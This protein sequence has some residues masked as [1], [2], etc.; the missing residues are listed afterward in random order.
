MLAEFKG[1]AQLRKAAVRRG[2]KKKKENSSELLYSF[3]RVRYCYCEASVWLLC[4]SSVGRSVRS[5]V[6]ADLPSIGIISAKT[7]LVVLTTECREM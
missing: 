6:C 4:I 1:V 3:S 5:Y 7:K 2:K